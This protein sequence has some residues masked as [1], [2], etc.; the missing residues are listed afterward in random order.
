MV[1]TGFLFVIVNVLV[2]ALGTDLPAAQSAFLRYAMGSV[3][4]IPM[5]KEFFQHRSTR[6]EQKV[7]I[8]RGIVHTGAV[9]LWFF[10]MARI[11][12]A[13]VTAMNY[14]SPIY[15]TM[16]AAILL[17]ERI[18]LRRVLA[19]LVAV[20]GVLLILRPGFRDVGLGH[21]AMIGAAVCFA[22]SYLFAKQAS[23]TASPAVVVTMLSLWV[24]LGLAPMAAVSWVPPSWTEIGVLFLVACAAT[25]AHYTM[26]I[27][28]K[29]AP[30]TVTQPVTFLQL[31]WAVSLGAILF[32]EPLDIWVILGGSLIMG[33]VVYI[34]WREAHLKARGQD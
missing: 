31:I 29:A 11:P 4:L 33:S 15:V 20:I 27:A 8:Y 26:T 7:F 9:T 5:L 25:A 3:L 28:F 2:K 14:M 17:G 12:L 1:V 34:S 10:A 13:D 6:S 16:G 30:V 18:K 24:T 19:I 23:N 21:V 32:N 22:A